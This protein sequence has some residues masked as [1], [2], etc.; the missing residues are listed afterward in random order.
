MDKRCTRPKEMEISK[1]PCYS[2]YADKL[3]YRRDY[4]SWMAKYN[5]KFRETALSCSRRYVY[6]R[7]HTDP[8]YREKHLEYM[9]KRQHFL[10]HNDPEFRAKQDKMTSERSKFRWR[11]DPEFREIGIR[12]SKER[13]HANKVLKRGKKNE[14]ILQ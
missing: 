3:Q 7:Y 11:N 14:N 9:K 12:R 10:Y 4:Q 6:K 8:V 1:K 2:D 5:T 13:Y